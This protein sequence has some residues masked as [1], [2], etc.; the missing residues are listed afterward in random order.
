[1]VVMVVVVV[2]VCKT[3]KASSGVASS[4]RSVRV[5][6]HACARMSVRVA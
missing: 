2:V 5:C 4:G 6:V 1:M 3:L